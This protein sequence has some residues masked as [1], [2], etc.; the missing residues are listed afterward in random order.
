MIG[1]YVLIEFHYERKFFICVSL[2]PP[3][4]MA[5]IALVI[6]TIAVV[7][8]PPLA[9]PA[10]RDGVV[11]VA[12]EVV[13]LALVELLGQH[14]RDKGDDRQVLHFAQTH[15]DPLDEREEGYGGRHGVAAK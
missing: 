12:V 1:P 8:V 10:P 4:A 5:L 11:V 7:V 6:F 9:T 13:M 2:E 14:A 15:G 3:E